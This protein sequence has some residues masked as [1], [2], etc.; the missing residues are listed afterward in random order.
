MSSMDRFVQWLTGEEGEEPAAA[1]HAASRAVDGSGLP[2]L[3]SNA[4]PYG[5]TVEPVTV[6]PGTR[7]WRITRVH[8]LGRDE[9]GGRHHIYIDAVQADGSRAFNSQAHVTWEGGEHVATVDKPPNEPGTNFPLFKWQVC[10]VEMLGMPSDRVRGIS[11]GHPDEPYPDG[12]ESGNTLFHHS[13]LIIFQEVTAPQSVTSGTIQGRVENSRE[14]LRVELVQ[15]EKVVA[16]APV[17]G[18]GAFSFPAVAAGDYS[19]RLEEQSI[20]VHVQAGQT[21]TVALSLAASESIIEGTVQGGGGLLLRLIQGGAVMAE[22]PLGQ[23]GA[24]RLRNLAAGLYHV[25]VLRS[26]QAE[27]LVTSGALAM[28]GRNR[29][30]VELAIPV[31]DAPGTVAPPTFP[32]ASAPGSPLDHYVLFSA[33]DAPEGRAQLAALLPKLAEK[34]LGF[35]FDY[36]EAAHAKQVTVVGDGQSIPDFQL[37]YLTT[38]GVKVR[39]L[40]GTPQENAAQL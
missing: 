29:R 18:D 15:A 22:G 26:S 4:E 12:T 30:T 11:S 8:H 31:A 32:V 35:G 17:A 6:A 1:K 38:R 21:A 10:T 40:T 9:N 7:Y 13:F 20:P 34:R 25:H 2:S 16:S 3:E 24:F 37:D 28:D 39:R 19:L 36:Q 33:I 23:S 5:V 14:G 27:P